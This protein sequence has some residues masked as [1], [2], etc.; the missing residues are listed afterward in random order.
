MV[1]WRASCTAVGMKLPQPDALLRF[2]D[3]QLRE[4]DPEPLDGDALELAIADNHR[5]NRLLWEAEDQARR[6]DVP[7]EYIVGCKRAI[8][9]HN[10][11]RNDAVERIDEALLQRLSDAVPAEQARLHSETPGAIIDR[12]SILALK[13]HHMGLRAHSADADDEHIAACSAKLQVLITQ[14]ND[15]ATCLSSLLLELRQ[16]QARFRVYRQFK[17]YNDPALNPW[18]RGK[19]PG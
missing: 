8:D 7:D 13:I 18:L 16:G 9:R 4:P 17:M 10:Q 12:L 11:R 14:R 1:R 5:C 19:P 15:L 3:R 2:H 6:P